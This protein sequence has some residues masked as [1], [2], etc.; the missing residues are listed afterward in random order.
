M[1]FKKQLAEALEQAV[2]RVPEL[3][4]AGSDILRDITIE[5]PAR[6]GHGDYASSLPLKLARLTGKKPMDVAQVIVKNMP[7]MVDIEKIAIVPPGF[8]N[9]TLS[10][11][12]L[13]G[14][15]DII[16]RA[17][18]EYGNVSPG[19]KTIQIE[20]V[21]GNPT[22]PLHVGH[23]RGAVLGSALA[24]VLA[25]AGYRVNTEYYINDA[26]SQL[27]AFH[28]SLWA[29]YQQAL[30]KDAEVPANG[31]HGTYVID[32]AKEIIEVSGDKYL[33]MPPEEGVAEIG[34]VGIER[35]MSQIKTDLTALG[36]NFDVWFSEQSL[37]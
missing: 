20:F 13:T 19:D 23:G 15:V 35:E 4:L 32:L 9:F 16:C 34:R 17:G 26:G 14:Q 18:E 22:G 33:K 24:L 10:T 25:A 6:A 21:S 7:A 2:A 28:R 3:G 31:Y 36:V 29:R 30:G 8:I 5:K 1:T 27:E 11:K 12:W 37:F